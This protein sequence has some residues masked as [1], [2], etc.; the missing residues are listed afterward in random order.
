MEAFY[1]AQ[2]IFDSPIDS[3]FRKELNLD[4]FLRVPSG[5]PHSKTTKEYLFLLQPCFNSQTK[6]LE[7]SNTLSR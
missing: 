6:G 1:K 5:A 7:N 4:H 2:K 3:E